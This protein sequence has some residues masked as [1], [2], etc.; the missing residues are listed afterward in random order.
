MVCYDLGD[1]PIV[2][3]YNYCQRTSNCFYIP[4]SIHIPLQV[5]VLL[6]VKGFKVAL[7]GM[8]RISD[9]LG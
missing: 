8:L 6:G 3:V 5:S 1:A 7:C 4:V 9:L 2:V